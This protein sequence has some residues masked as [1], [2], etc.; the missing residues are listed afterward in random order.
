MC[1]FIE[2]IDVNDSEWHKK[3]NFTSLEELEKH[4]KDVNL[5]KVD[6]VDINFML[7]KKNVIEQLNYPWFQMNIQTGDISGDLYFLLLCKE[8][9]IDI[10]VML[11][12]VI[13]IE[14]RLVV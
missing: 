13:G 14:K 8:K 9:N 10:F 7:I 4:K 2:S 1:N 3:T 12:V 6:Y 11:D 5:L